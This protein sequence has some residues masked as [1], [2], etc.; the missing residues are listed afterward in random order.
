[1]VVKKTKKIRRTVPMG[2]AYVHAGMNNTIV[3]I[4]D[5]TGQ[6]LARAS[7]GASGFKGTKK[8]TPYAAHVAAE[9]VVEK[10]KAFGVEIVDVYV[11]GIGPGREQAVRGLIAGGINVNTIIDKTPVA[12]NGCRKRK[13]R[14]V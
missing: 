11:R 7:S 8:S 14:R 12:H 13:A 3:S 9:G 2:R 5:P 4:T 1:M 6:I 10:C